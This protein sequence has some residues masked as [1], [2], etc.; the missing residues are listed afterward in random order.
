MHTILCIGFT[1]I[2]DRM[3]ATKIKHYGFSSFHRYFFDFLD[4]AARPGKGN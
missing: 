3:L 1:F 2:N 4:A